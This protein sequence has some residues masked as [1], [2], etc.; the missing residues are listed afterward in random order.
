MICVR[1]AIRE[2][3]V[4]YRW[5]LRPDILIIK[6]ISGRAGLIFNVFVG[7]RRKYVVQHFRRNFGGDLEKESSLELNVL[8]EAVS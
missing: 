7:F 8:L 3:K 5:I 1:E 2:Q 4:R 6:V